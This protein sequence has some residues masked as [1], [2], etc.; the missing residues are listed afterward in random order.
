VKSGIST[1][2]YTWAIGVPGSYP[3]NPLSVYSL[4]SKASS[5][6]ADC[7]QLADNLPFAGFSDAELSGI[8]DYAK[9]N[10][11]AIEIGGRGL[12]E[13][14][15]DHHIDLATFFGSPFLRMVIDANNYQPD[16]DTILAVI[17]NA[18]GKLRSS[19]LI[20]ALENHDRLHASVFR[21][22]VEKSGPDCTGICLDC[23]NS[24]GIAEG[25]DTVLGYLAP[26]TVNLHIKDFVVKRV[27]HKM[28]FI[29]EGVPAGKGLLN[30]HFV[31][32]KLEP[33]GKCRSAILEL[34]TP[35]ADNL[36][37][38]IRREEEW[39]IESFKFIKETLY[40]K[41]NYPGRGRR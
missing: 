2:T 1:Y 37:E 27:S 16:M 19:G 40:E 6:K 23:A 10:G 38:T 3:E 25:I 11:I 4:I 32:E 35:P 7:V 20:L 14:N 36:E 13:E 34:W 8:R 29:V 15:L 22:I 24:L 17:S 9:N 5:L 28:G 39:A 12:T 41:E 33:F 26:Y 31:L 30:L 18:A 21:E